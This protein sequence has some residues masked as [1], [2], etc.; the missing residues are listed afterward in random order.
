MRAAE[1]KSALKGEFGGVKLVERIPPPFLRNSTVSLYKTAFED[2][3][4]Q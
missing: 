1:R 3:G 4:A 2:C